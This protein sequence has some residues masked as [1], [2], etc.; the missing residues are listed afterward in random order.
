MDLYR[1][2]FQKTLSNAYLMLYST[3][4]FK[5]NNIKKY[6]KSNF[7]L[8]FEYVDDIDKSLCGKLYKKLKN[9]LILYY[10]IILML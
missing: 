5:I 6:L 2:Y 1:N 7:K 9:N 4:Y 10:K 8:V 3:N